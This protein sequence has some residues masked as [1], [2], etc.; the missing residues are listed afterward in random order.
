MTTRKAAKT[1]GTMHHH[2]TKTYGLDIGYGNTKITDGDTHIV[3][4]SVAAHAHH[5]KFQADIISGKYPGEELSDND[6]EWFI[7]D[8]AIKQAPIKQRI[9]LQGRNANGQFDMAFRLRMMY[10]ALA[11]IAPHQNG[12]VLHV[13]IATGLPVDHM[14]DAHLMKQAM[15]GQHR[16]K[17]NNAD[18]IA[19]VSDCIVM[20]QPYGTIYGEMITEIGELNHYHTASRTAVVDIGQYTLDC[21]LDNDGEYIDAESGS[22]ESGVYT[23]IERITAIFAAEFRQNPTHDQIEKLLRTGFVMISG[24]MVDYTHHVKEALRPLRDGV[25]NLMGRLWGTAVHIDLI[26]LCGGGVTF[27]EEGVLQNYPQARVVLNP[28]VSNAIGYLRY[29]SF[30]ARQPK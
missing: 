13:K 16:I 4:P 28:Q 11:K 24:E 30:D 2:S 7:G 20:P 27:V 21:A 19:N 26:L 14:E 5:I 18:F 10:S 15:I 1:Q 8:L 29:A 3:F 6:G 25:L 23:A 17:T 9:R 22:L 12:E